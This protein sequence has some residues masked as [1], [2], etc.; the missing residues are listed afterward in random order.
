MEG[1]SD[2]ILP[3]L[4]RGGEPDNHAALTCGAAYCPGNCLAPATSMIY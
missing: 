2:K 3:E 4:V 1:L